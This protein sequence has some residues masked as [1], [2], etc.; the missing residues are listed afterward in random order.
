MKPI[1]KKLKENRKL[2]KLPLSLRFGNMTG[3]FANLRPAK[4]ELQKNF[5]KVAR[6]NFCGQRPNQ[7]TMNVWLNFGNAKDCADAMKLIEEKSPLGIKFLKIGETAE[8]FFT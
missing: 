8:K 4:E 5:P 6:I 1:I 7:N 3:V 2:S